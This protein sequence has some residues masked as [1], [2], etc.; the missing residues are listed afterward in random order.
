MFALNL[1]SWR[2]LTRV[3]TCSLPGKLP[4]QLENE[5]LRVVARFVAHFFLSLRTCSRLRI[6]Q[7]T[8]ARAL[9]K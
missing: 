9:F 3:N 8:S 7:L 6:A 1:A 2:A 4:S 5:K